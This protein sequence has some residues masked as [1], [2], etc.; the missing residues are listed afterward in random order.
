M[1]NGT[2]R[3]SVF[4]NTGLGSASDRISRRQRRKK[5]LYAVISALLI[6][7]ALVIVAAIFCRVS[8]VEITG[9]GLYT[10]KEIMD[11]AGISYGMQL[12]HIKRSEASDGIRKSLSGIENAKI[13]FALPNKVKINVTEGEPFY[14]FEAGGKLYYISEN[15]IALGS[16]LTVTDGDKLCRLDGAQIKKYVAGNKVAFYDEDWYYIIESLVSS[17]KLSDLYD[18]LTVIETAD[19]FNIAV[20]YDSRIR[21]MLGEYANIEEKLE[22]AKSTIDSLEIDAVGTIRIKNYKVGSFLRGEY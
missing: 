1:A 11:A 9:T 22:F 5:I 2:R 12:F 15:F 13:S 17:L 20:R 7:G 3:V 10:D 16:S 8:A 18:K 21:I 14:Y 19:K 6:A 4:D